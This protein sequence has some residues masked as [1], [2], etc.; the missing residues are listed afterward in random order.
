MVQRWQTINSENKNDTEECW[1]GYSF[2]SKERGVVG[3]EV[4]GD[5]DK[6]EK[7]DRYDSWYKYGILQENLNK[8]FWH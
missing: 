7:E 1:S 5:S 8:I 2:V 4:G 3:E 6:V